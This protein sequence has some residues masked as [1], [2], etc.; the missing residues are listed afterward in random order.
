MMRNIKPRYVKIAE[1]LESE[2]QKLAPNSL[3]PTEEQMAGRFDVS[4]VTLRSALELL[5]NNG[6]IS[7][8]RGRGTIVSPQ[9]VIR[10]FSPLTSFE[11]DMRN[12]G[13]AVVTQVLSFEKNLVAPTTV[14]RQLELP[15]DSRVVYLSLNKLVDDRVICHDDRY[16]PKEIG[17]KIDPLKAETVDSSEILEEAA[18]TKIRRVRWES[19]IISASQDIASALGIANR[20]LVFTSNYTWFA[21]GGR[22]IETGLISYR[23]DRCKFRLQ[24]PFQHTVARRE[25]DQ[26]SKEAPPTLLGR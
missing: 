2:L 21:K 10:N 15:H 26:A 19:E 13:V 9:K 7:R 1:I 5:E 3:L 6:L 23:I 14:A 22:P 11:S 12:Q 8:L 25:T 24:E 17:C 4:R 16:Y 20:T 18:G